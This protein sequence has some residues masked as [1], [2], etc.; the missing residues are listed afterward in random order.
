[1]LSLGRAAVSLVCAGLI[2]GIAVNL[3]A[4]TFADKLIRLLCG[5]FLTLTLLQPLKQLNLPELSP[6][7]DTYRNDANL[8]AQKGEQLAEQARLSGIKQ[9]LRAYILDKA[10]QLNMNIEAQIM[11][12]PEGQPL[13]VE[14]VGV[15]DEAA[16]K[17]LSGYLETQLGIA[18][19]D[20]QWTRKTSG[21]GQQD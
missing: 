5:L 15:Y 2:C 20:Q 9:R 8:A 21:D 14:I 12:S 13:A 17:T 7:L 4:D 18:K 11:L 16:R 3:T 19:E 1:M 10:K 6:I